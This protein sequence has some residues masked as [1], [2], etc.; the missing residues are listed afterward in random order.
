MRKRD[1]SNHLQHFGV[2][3]KVDK[4]PKTK[5]AKKIFRLVLILVIIIL[6]IF[7]V[8]KSSFFKIKIIT[9]S[10]TINSQ[11][12][13]ET[14][15]NIKGYLADHSNYLFL[16][17]NK[18]KEYIDERVQLEKLDINKVFPNKLEID[19][20]PEIPAML[21]QEDQ[22]YFLIDSEGVVETQINL[23]QLEW[24]LP[25]VTLATT[26]R[27]LVGEKLVND[28]FINFIKEFN[29][30]FKKISF[31]LNLEK[32]IISDLEGR[33]VKVYTNQGWY[34]LVSTDNMVSNVLNNLKSLVNEKFKEEKPNQYVDLR[35]EDKIF[36]K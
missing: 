14:E 4:K 13:D 26:T 28:N 35:L 9:I 8:F 29:Q 11:L 17:K 25:T 1:Y 2:A 31:D 23:S 19:I 20:S 18:L 36:Y 7:I 12:I 22:E 10:G 34:I 32:Y 5:K 33:E 27:V 15:R 3:H 6:I 21:W 24:E 16:N 30:E